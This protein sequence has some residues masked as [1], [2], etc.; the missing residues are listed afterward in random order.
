MFYVPNLPYAFYLAAKAKHSAFFS[1]VN[2]SIKSSG[3]GTESKY[4]TLQLVPEKFKPKSVLHTYNSN[5]ED[6]F[7]AIKKEGITYPLIAKPDIGFRGLLVQKINSEKELRTYLEKYIINIIIQEYV[8]CKNESG[9]FYHRNPNEQKG[10][11]SSIT[12]KKF[13]CVT[14]NGISTLEQLILLDVRAKLYFSLLLEIHKEKLKT[15]PKNN[16]IIQLSVIGNHSKGTQFINGNHLISK[17]LEQTFDALSHQIPGWFYGRVDLKYNDFSEVE[18]GNNFKIIEINGIISEPTHIYD[19][20][21][22]SYFTALKSIRTHW[23][24]LYQISKTNHEEHQIPYKSSKKF[25]SEMVELRAYTKK[26]K[27][28]SRL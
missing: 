4:Q 25:I 6:T 2:P 18:N 1:A 7:L 16:Q 9:I 22:S 3:N 26:V 12:L 15:I 19:A 10:T 24:L 5:L 14:G 13:L 11:I 28:V 21:N 17:K 20:Q 27:L 8:S 23:K